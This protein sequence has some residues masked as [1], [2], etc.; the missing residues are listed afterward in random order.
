VDGKGLK[1]GSNPGSR[2]GNYSA[3]GLTQS[4]GRKSSLPSVTVTPLCL[5]TVI[6]KPSSGSRPS[7]APAES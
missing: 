6:I 1:S 2:V 3:V 4:Q 5:S 7:H